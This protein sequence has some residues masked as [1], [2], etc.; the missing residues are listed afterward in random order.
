[1]RACQ[2]PMRTASGKSVVT[3]EGLDAKG[4]HPLQVA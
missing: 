2:T 4:Q 1:V 3:I